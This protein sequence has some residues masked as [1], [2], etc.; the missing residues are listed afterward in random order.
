MRGSV[1][2]FAIDDARFSEFLCFLDEGQELVM[3][4]VRLM[5]VEVGE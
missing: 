1:K 4:I 5:I 2:I 3:V